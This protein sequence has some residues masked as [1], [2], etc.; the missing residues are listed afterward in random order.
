MQRQI[1]TKPPQMS[2]T[3]QPRRSVYADKL[4]AFADFAFGDDAVF[5]NRGR[6]REF[7]RR[8][9]GPAYD[10]RLVFEIGCSDADFLARVACRFP[11]TAF[12][13]LDWKARALYDAA[14]RVAAQ[15]WSN[16]ALLRGRAQDVSKIFDEG[17]VDEIWVFHPDP[18]DR[19]VELKNR[20][21]AEPFLVEAHRVLR[22]EHSVLVLKTDHAGYYQSV[23]GLFAPPGEELMRTENAPCPGDAVQRLF[24]LTLNAPDY[25]HDAVALAHTRSRPFAGET[26]AYERR[27]LRKRR[28]IM[29]VELRKG[30]RAAK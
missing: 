26:T 21:I 24:T 23:L 28:P 29:Y 30:G 8:R 15:Q 16:I 12:V 22:D 25:W 11:N 6:W 17:E 10:G 18:C 9:V 7:F 27:F 3:Q 20:L 13:G 14:G 5:H 4:G 1:V 2:L 19:D